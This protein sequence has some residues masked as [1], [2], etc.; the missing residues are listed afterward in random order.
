MNRVENVPEIE[1]GCRRDSGIGRLKRNW[2]GMAGILLYSLPKRC[3]RIAIE[4]CF[5]CRIGPDSACLVCSGDRDDESCRICTENQSQ[6]SSLLWNGLDT[7]VFLYCLVCSTD[8]DNETCRKSTGKRSLSLLLLRTG[9]NIAA[10]ST[11]IAASGE[12]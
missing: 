11:V 10:F 2:C 12:R 4:V 6:L 5:L 1:H 3:R 9:L 7:A 8:C